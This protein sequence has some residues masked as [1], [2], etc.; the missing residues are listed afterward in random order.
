[1]Q[2][3]VWFYFYV[4]DI[5]KKLAEELRCDLRS[6]EINSLCK[7]AGNGTLNCIHFSIH[8]LPQEMM[9][10][11]VV[12]D[13]SKVFESIWDNTCSKLDEESITTF[14]D[15][16]EHV[17]NH[18]I[19]TC[20]DLLYKL[21]NKSFTYTDINFKCF[22]N[23]RNIN[24]HVAALYNA[25]HQ[26]YG[27]SLVSLLPDPKQWMPRAVKYITMYLDFAKYSSDTVQINAV[28]LCLKMKDL[29]KLKGNFS[30]V[31][32]LNIQVCICYETV[33]SVLE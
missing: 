5:T 16:H 28:Q 20:K 22:T 23:A 26:C 1:M 7:D 33:T 19:V 25:M 2:S 14:N 18:T 9:E 6:E 10:Y 27:D 32:S 13:N 3:C 29:L 24:I 8:K 15:I 31:N 11:L 21:Y 30:V 17:W 12:F 4:I